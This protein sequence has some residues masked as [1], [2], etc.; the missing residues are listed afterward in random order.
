MHQTAESNLIKSAAGL[1]KKACGVI[2]I[3]ERIA[4][5][6]IENTKSPIKSRTWGTP[7]RLAFW[8]EEE[9]RNEVGGDFSTKKEMSS[10]TSV[11]CDD[12]GADNRS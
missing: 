7:K 8:G 9:Q 11:V 10:Q 2:H 1:F 12:D 4:G 6:S 3:I 5:I